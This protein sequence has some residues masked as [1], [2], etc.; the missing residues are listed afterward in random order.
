[1]KKLIMI[2]CLSL[3]WMGCATSDVETAA[4]ADEIGTVT[5]V[6]PVIIRSSATD[7]ILG[8]APGSGGAFDPQVCTEYGCDS[9]G[10]NCSY[11]PSGCGGDGGGGGG[12]CSIGN[13][14]IGAQWGCGGGGGGVQCQTGSAV[15]TSTYCLVQACLD[16]WPGETGYR[17]THY[18]QTTTCSD[19]SIDSVYWSSD[20]W[21]PAG[22]PR[23]Q[24]CW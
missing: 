20:V 17:R 3:I 16:G 12:G 13:D 8:V 5:P 4:T 6:T 1:M 21:D 10:R 9:E 24:F 7:P 15:V 11:F 23:A 19:G 14:G 18:S 2:L 22:C